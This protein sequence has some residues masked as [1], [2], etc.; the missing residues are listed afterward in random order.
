MQDS[1]HHTM[2]INSNVGGGR[3]LVVGVYG[4]NYVVCYKNSDR[5]V[6]G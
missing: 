4:E 3:F 2:A 1:M 6:N 5:A